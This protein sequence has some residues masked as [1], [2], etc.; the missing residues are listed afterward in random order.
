[1]WYN[2]FLILDSNVAFANFIAGM[3]GEKS[4]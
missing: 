4:A 1:M 3:A 2:E